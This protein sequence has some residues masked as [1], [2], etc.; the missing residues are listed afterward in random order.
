MIFECIY[1]GVGTALLWYFR[2]DDFYCV[3]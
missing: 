3:G 1:F 2:L